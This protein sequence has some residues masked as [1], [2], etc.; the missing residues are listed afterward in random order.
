MREG[1][2][3]AGDGPIQAAAAVVDVDGTRSRGRRPRRAGRSSDSEGDDGERDP[4]PASILTPARFRESQHLVPLLQLALLQEADQHLRI[5]LDQ[6][7]D[8]ATRC[9]RCLRESRLLGVAVGRCSSR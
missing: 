6:Y 8:L 3:S 4:S 7:D 9:E 2:P 1:Y 5:V